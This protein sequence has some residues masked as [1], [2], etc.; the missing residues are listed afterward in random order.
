MFLLCFW[1]STGGGGSGADHYYIC[2]GAI[3]VEA[4]WKRTME[5]ESLINMGKCTKSYK[6]QLQNQH[7]KQ[8]EDQQQRQLWPNPFFLFFYFFFSLFVILILPHTFYIMLIM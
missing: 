4:N 8:K 6:S 5:R 2:W 3:K 7:Q 1:R